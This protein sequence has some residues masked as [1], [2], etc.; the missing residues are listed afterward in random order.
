VKRR[1]ERQTNSSSSQAQIVKA[2]LRQTEKHPLRETIRL[3]IADHHVLI[4]EGLAETIGRQDNMTVLA[5]AAG[6]H[7]NGSRQR[8]EP[9]AENLN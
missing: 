3:L 7:F 8:L 6:H 5:K 2:M 4:I 1:R 9:I